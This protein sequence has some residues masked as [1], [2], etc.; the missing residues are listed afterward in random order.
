MSPPTASRMSV[1][2]PPKPSDGY[3]IGLDLS[4]HVG[5]QSDVAR[6]FTDSVGFVFGNERA[7]GGET[8]LKAKL[9]A[10]IQNYGVLWQPYVSGSVH[11]DFDYSHIANFPGQLALATGDSLIFADATTFVGAKVGLDVKTTFGWTIGVNGYYERSSDTEIVGGQAYV[12][13]PL[14]PAIVTA[15]Y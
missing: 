10:N 6:G 5:Y 8:G 7:Q 13:I 4:G 12:K 14:G 9:F 11:W 2:A 15:R 3:A 1:K